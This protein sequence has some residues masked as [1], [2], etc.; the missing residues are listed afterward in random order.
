MRLNKNK[1]INK[2]THSSSNSK[3]SNHSPLTEP[4][5]I[6]ESVFPVVGIGASAGGLDAIEKFFLNMPSDNAIPS[7]PKYKK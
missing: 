3:K 1:E 2:K 4:A 7:P 5:P 6:T